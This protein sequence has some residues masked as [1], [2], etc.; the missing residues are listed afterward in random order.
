[1]VK[2]GQSWG[3]VK[4]SVLN[5]VN[6]TYQLRP[7]LS[8]SR[9][10]GYD[11][12]GIHCGTSDMDDLAH[13]IISDAPLFDC[14]FSSIAD[15]HNPAVKKQLFLHCLPS[16]FFAQKKFLLFLILRYIKLRFRLI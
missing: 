11:G 2:K 10:T 3:D 1:M 14:D 6:G 5:I 15:V 8:L 16:G 12:S 4:R 9:N 7:S 13:Q